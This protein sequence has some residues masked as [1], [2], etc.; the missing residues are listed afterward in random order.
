MPQRIKTAQQLYSN[1]DNSPI[2]VME[3]MS[4]ISQQIEQA[5]H[6]HHLQIQHNAFQFCID[7]WRYVVKNQHGIAPLFLA[8][9]SISHQADP[10]QRTPITGLPS[11]TK[12]PPGVI[13]F[14]C[15]IS[16]WILSPSLDTSTASTSIRTPSIIG[17]NSR[18]LHWNLFSK[19][20]FP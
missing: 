20:F 5:A 7:H 15:L 1:T 18:N 14:R 16:H 19:A 3:R 11:R 17:H 6:S 10:N 8:N 2:C 4:V 9:L 13:K 12:L